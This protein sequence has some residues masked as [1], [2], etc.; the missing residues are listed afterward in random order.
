[1]SEISV[2]VSIWVDKAMNRIKAI[3]NEYKYILLVIT[4]ACLV[5][6][7]IFIFGDRPFLVNADQQLQYNIFYEEWIRL[8]EE[9]FSG[10]GLPMYSWNSFLGTDFFAAN[11]YYLTGDIFLP[12]LL[13]IHDIE[14]ALFIETL[15]CVYISAIAMNAFLKEFGIEKQGVRNFNSIIYAISGWATLYYGQYMFHRFYAFLPLLFLGVEYFI[16]KRKSS[17]FIFAVAILFLQSYYL[18][19]PTTLFLLLYGIFTEV[20]RKEKVSKIIRDG[21]H[22]M[23]RFLVGFCM[24]LVVIMP[25]LIYLSSNPRIGVVENVG[26]LWDLNVYLGFIINLITSPFPVYTNYPNLFYSGTNGHA[27][28]YS[29]LVGI[30]PLIFA[31]TLYRNKKYKSYLAVSLVLIG[32]LFIKPLSS[33]MHGFSE[34]SLRWSFL[35]IFF[36]ILSSAKGQDIGVSSRELKKSLIIYFS[37]F[38]GT[39]I[40]G[41]IAN[42]IEVETFK[43]HVASIG[44]SLLL[45]LFIAIVYLKHEKIA[46]CI[47]IAQLILMAAGLLYVYNVNYYRYEESINRE[48]VNYFKTADDDLMFRYYVDPAHLMPSSQLNLNKSLVFGMMSTSTYNTLYEASLVPFLKTNNVGWH[49]IHLSEPS[50]MDVLGVKYYIVYDET[51]LPTAYQFEYAYDLNHLKVYL[52]SDFKGFG[53]TLADIDYF[54]NFSDTM[55]YEETLF[56]DDSNINIAKYDGGT[57]SKFNVYE[58][59]NNYLKGTVY[60]NESNILFLPIPNNSGWK[61]IVNGVKKETISVNGGF[62]GIELEAGDSDI[63]LYFVTPGLKTGLL[64]SVISLLLAGLIIFYERRRH[65]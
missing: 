43:L 29:L 17:I 46:I 16:N 65:V 53:Y 8:V 35:I 25:A 33:V 3:F 11:A 48:Y 26:V 20:R 42:I 50:I 39:I 12:L 30:L 51:E 27:Y 55:D 44:I 60:L 45:A 47:Q 6:F 21:L 61:V 19:F 63:Q 1:M 15:A 64:I 54:S 37:V 28:W 38:V 18:M 24:S 32:F 56:V 58:V 7:G 13:H 40:L 23:L 5:I 59:R 10:N 34:P 41:F 31:I 22:L 57:C 9:F 52:R 4:V 14:L 36:I 49:I 2:I 62:L